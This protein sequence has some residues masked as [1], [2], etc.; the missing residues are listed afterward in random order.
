MSKTPIKNLGVTGTFSATGQVVGLSGGATFGGDIKINNTTLNET[1]LA[2]L[3]SGNAIGSTGAT[4]PEGSWFNWTY[5][6]CRWRRRNRS[7][8]VLLV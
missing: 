6:C 1:K 7:L 5:R 3:V 2:Q 4:G 8:L